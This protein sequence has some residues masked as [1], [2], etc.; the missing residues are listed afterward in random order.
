M[1]NCEAKQMSDQMVCDFC[2]QVWDVNDPE[3]P[4]CRWQSL[5]S[6][7]AEAVE[8]IFDNITAIG[9]RFRAADIEQYAQKL[10]NGEDNE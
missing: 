5:R 6:I 10:R 1:S 9:G 7:Q 4:Q 3:P 2:E 8:S